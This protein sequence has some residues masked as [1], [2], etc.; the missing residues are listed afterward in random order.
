M[1]PS[2]NP[3]ELEQRR[4]RAVGLLSQGLFP[5]EAA[6]QTGAEPRSVPR[7]NAAART[8]ADQ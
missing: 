8:S 6:R 7:L 5:H 2:G 1:R 3:H 4:L